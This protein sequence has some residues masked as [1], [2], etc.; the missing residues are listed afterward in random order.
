VTVKEAV[1]FVKQRGIVL[2]S[3]AGSVPNL[4][5]HIAGGPIRGNWWGHPKS[6][7][8]FALTRAIRDRD[9][10]LL[11]RLVQGRVTYVHRRLWPA[12][13]RL[14]DCFPHERLVAFREIHTSRGQHALEEQPFLEWV[15]PEI[16]RAGK[17]LSEARALAVLASY[18]AAIGL[19]GSA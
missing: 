3:A 2:E 6:R 15:P 4:A 1:A 14:A 5:A 10:V 17:K 19:R 8:I 18:A 11:S 9:D 12:L 13:V 16:R 7:E